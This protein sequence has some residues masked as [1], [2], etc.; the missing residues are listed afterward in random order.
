MTP[1]LRFNGA[2]LVRGGRTVLGGLDFAVPNGA[3][4]GVFGPNGAGKT[5]L[6]RA[7]LGLVPPAG[8]TIEVLGKAPTRGNPS[9]GYMPQSRATLGDVRLSGRSFVASAACGVAWGLPRLDR[10]QH[11]DVERVLDLADATAYAERAVGT[12]SGGERQRLLLA[13]ALLGEP[14]LLLLDE[15]LASL[16]PHHQ[17]TT[18]ALVR[19]LQRRLGITVLF[20]AHELT[21]LVPVLD[22]VLYLGRGEAALGTVD[23][24]VT[25][26]TLSR[27]YGARIDVVR[28]QGRIFVMAGSVFADGPAPQEGAGPAL[29]GQMQDAHAAL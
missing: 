15:P 2:S 26:E 18:I 10:A 16:D 17:E 28:A 14:R 6:M 7:I 22:Q 4:V 23:E 1:S 3:F 27:L 5:T 21:A 9:I 25:P 12:L 24:V 29:S 19:R 13:Q 8:G 20:S 11:Q